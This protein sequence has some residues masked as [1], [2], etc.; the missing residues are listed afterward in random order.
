MKPTTQN[1]VFFDTEEYAKRIDNLPKEEK[2]L[3]YLVGV[4]S[5]EGKVIKMI[6][7]LE[8]EINER[9][10]LDPTGIRNTFIDGVSYSDAIVVC[11]PEH[12]GELFND[13][14]EGD[15]EEFQSYVIAKDLE[16]GVAFKELVKSF[17]RRRL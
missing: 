7:M 3:F 4:V 13:I 5:D 17:R 15:Y 2:T 14:F 10:E 9:I 8:A 16:L 1:L 6:P 11:S 12:E